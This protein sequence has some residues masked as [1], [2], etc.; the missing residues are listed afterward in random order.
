METVFANKDYTS[1]ENNKNL[2]KVAEVEKTCSPLQ[3]SCFERLGVWGIWFQVEELCLLVDPLDLVNTIFKDDQYWMLDFYNEQKDCYV[4]D[5]RKLDFCMEWNLVHADYPTYYFHFTLED[6]IDKIKLAI[7]ELYNAWNDCMPTA[8]K[9]YD[10]DINGVEMCKKQLE[11]GATLLSNYKLMTS[12][13][14]KET[15]V[16]TPLKHV[17]KYTIGIG[18]RTFDTFLTHWDSDMETIRHQF[19]TYVY[20]HEAT[21]RLPFDMTD[22]IIQLSHRRVLDK[23][24][25][26]KGG[27]GFQ[28]KDYCLVTITPNDFVHMPI[29]KGYYDEK[30]VI[31]TLYEG[32]MLM[33]FKHP[34]NG[35]E[36]SHDDLPSRIV[37]Y[38][39]YKSPII[40]SFI[41]SEEIV[42]NTYRQRQVNVKE[43]ITICPDYGAFLWW[44]KFDEAGCVD[45]LYDKD[46]VPI[47]FEELEEWAKEA[48]PAIAAFHL[49]KPYE[50]NWADYHRRGIALAKQLR[51]RLSTDFDLWY[52]AP[53]EDKSETIKHPILIL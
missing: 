35:K 14:I 16:F 15:F 45:E 34:T 2:R 33:A 28:Y 41:K 11:V 18:N 25:K 7:N 37:T 23:I 24:D 5:A 19:E 44:N 26:E 51:E 48:E 52:D 43:I 3:I 29:I 6:Y 31:R 30:E 1:I 49:E 42:P 39:R 32:F 13:V 40:E 53:F 10:F 9:K 12:S 47:E 36:S 20:E 8:Y 38:N 21:I 22:T 4:V 17:E 50:M 27:Y 46:N